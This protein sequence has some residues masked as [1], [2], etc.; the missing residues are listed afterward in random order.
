MPAPPHY[1]VI[2]PGTQM[3][4]QR[5]EEEGD[6]QMVEGQQTKIAQRDLLM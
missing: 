6:V 1:P 2:S 3:N 4:F 5:T